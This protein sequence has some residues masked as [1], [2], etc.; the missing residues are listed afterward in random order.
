LT[1]LKST[2]LE[3]FFTDLARLGLLLGYV[4][5]IEVL[6]YLE[7]LVLLGLVSLERSAGTY[8]ELI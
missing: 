1:H 4:Q 7:E 2:L 5:V 3:I 6:A 8:E